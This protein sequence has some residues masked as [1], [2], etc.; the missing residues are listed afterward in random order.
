MYS[1]YDFLIFSEKCKTKPF[2]TQN[3]YF[4]KFTYIIVYIELKY[5][6]QHTSRNIVEDT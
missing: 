3:F 4:Y 1:F 2:S 5:C 6:S